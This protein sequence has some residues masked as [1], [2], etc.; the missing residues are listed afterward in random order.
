MY[1]RRAGVLKKR[2]RTSTVV[3]AARAAGP[4]AAILPSS[5]VISAPMDSSADRLTMRSRDTAPMAASPSP[6]N[7]REAMWTRSSESEI[8]LVAW[9]WTAT[10]RSAAAIPPR[11]RTPG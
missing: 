10:A 7:P 5:T 2:S 3:P 8:L 4:G 11:R 1:F 6:R 9:R